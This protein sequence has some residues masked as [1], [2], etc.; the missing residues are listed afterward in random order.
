MAPMWR[1]CLK[2]VPLVLG[3]AIVICLGLGGCSRSLF[4]QPQLVTGGINSPQVDMQ[5]AFSGD[6]RYLAFCSDRFGRRDIYLF[7]NQ[8]RKLVDL[9]GLNRRNSAQEQPSLSND[10]RYVAYVSYERGRS[11]IFVYDRQTQGIDFLTA[12]IE[13]AVRHPTI[14]GNGRTVAFETSELGQ[15]NIAIVN[16]D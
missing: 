9:P 8:T 14:S 1:I 3:L 7:D 13:N 11:D 12:N 4:Y 16:R 2:K 5:P 15:W 6:G 10:G